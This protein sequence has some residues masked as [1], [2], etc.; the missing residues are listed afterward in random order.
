MEKHKAI[1]KGNI[2]KTAYKH[3]GDNADISTWD[4][5]KTAEDKIRVKRK[6]FESKILKSTVIDE[7][8][9]LWSGDI[10]SPLLNFREKVYIEEL[11]LEV[12]IK[13]RIRSTSGAYIYRTF[14]E[15]ERVES[16]FEDSEEKAEKDK[17]KFEADFEKE[18]EELKGEEKL[19]DSESVYEHYGMET[20]RKNQTWFE[21]WFD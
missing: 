18:I 8:R 15:I 17:I 13:E 1:I 2:N 19:K 4:H 10:D 7:E 6:Y 20:P 11:D 12:V 5:L 9:I 14:H 16:D 21:R 3:W